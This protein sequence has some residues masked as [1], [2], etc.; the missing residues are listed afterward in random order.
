VKLGKIGI[1][2]SLNRSHPR[3]DF[4]AVQM[5]TSRLKVLPVR[6]QL[7]AKLFYIAWKRF[8]SLNHHPHP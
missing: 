8:L 5:K 4:V 7:L 1:L 3:I 2:A 6:S